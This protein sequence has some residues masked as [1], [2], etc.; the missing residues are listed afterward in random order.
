MVFSNIIKVILFDRNRT[1][2]PFCTNKILMPAKDLADVSI[3]RFMPLSVEQVLDIVRF[4]R[5]GSP[6]PFQAV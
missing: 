2:L 5:T 4:L 6:P 3:M 1:D